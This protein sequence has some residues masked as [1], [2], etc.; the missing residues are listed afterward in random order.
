MGNTNLKVAKQLQ[1]FKK[2]IKDID[3]A[4]NRKFKG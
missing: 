4:N 2:P 1:L 3:V